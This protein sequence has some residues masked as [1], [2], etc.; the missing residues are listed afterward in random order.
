MKLLWAVLA[1]AIVAINY[2]YITAF[3]AVADQ[4]RELREV[5][6]ATAPQVAVG[7]MDP[8]ARITGDLGAALSAV[9][10]ALRPRDA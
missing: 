8:V 7:A 5:A 2:Y 10:G 9:Q 3:H 1:L 6:L 4:L